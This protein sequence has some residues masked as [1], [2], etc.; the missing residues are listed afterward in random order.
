MLAR[1]I[2]VGGVDPYLILPGGIDADECGEMARVFATIGTHAIV[3]T[4]LDIARR[5]GGLLSAAHQGGLAL[6][7][8]S[9][10]PKVADGF[11]SL[12]PKNVAKLFMPAAFRDHDSHDRVIKRSTA[13]IKRTGSA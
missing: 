12:S 8:G 2:G 3:P 7:D 1:M 4:R 11:I 13:P 9:N 10:T 5:L 6:S